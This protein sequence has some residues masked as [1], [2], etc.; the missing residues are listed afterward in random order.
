M[1]ARPPQHIHLTE[2]SWGPYI[3]EVLIPFEYGHH[4]VLETA[5][6]SILFL[7]MEWWRLGILLQIDLAFMCDNFNMHAF[8]SIAEVMVLILIRFLYFIL[9]S[10]SLFTVHV[11]VTTQ[12]WIL[13]NSLS[14]TLDLLYTVSFSWLLILRVIIH[15]L[16]GVGMF[17]IS[18]LVFICLA[19]CL[20]IP[21][22]Y[23]FGL[24]KS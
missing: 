19:I 10:W 24:E 20:R 21:L 7:Q 2:D 23:I 1:K 22:E 6:I 9:F 11:L 16:M 14:P 4:P 13:W 12:A 15:D 17:V 3:L 18:K 5:H 8:G